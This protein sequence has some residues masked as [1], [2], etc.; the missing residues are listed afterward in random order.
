MFNPQ[1][2]KFS[3]MVNTLARVHAGEIDELEAG[4]K[5]L[6]DEVGNVYQLVPFLRI[7]YK[8]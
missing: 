4:Y 2:E 7:V 3:N 6:K 1:F 8:G 5:E